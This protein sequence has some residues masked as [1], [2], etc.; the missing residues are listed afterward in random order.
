MAACCFARVLTTASTIIPPHNAPALCRDIAKSRTYRHPHLQ[1][2]CSSRPASLRAMKK[3]TKNR[4]RQ[5]AT[6]AAKEDA[7]IDLSEMPEVVDWSG[8]GNRKVLS[9]AEEACHHEA[10]HGHP[11]LAEELWARVPDQG[12][13]FAAACHA[14]LLQTHAAQ[15]KLTGRRSWP[16]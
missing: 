9:A 11:G 4:A 10:G 6:I 14:G 12:K 13:H 5:I 8:A 2:A 3:P 1:T 16:M 7:D 15:G